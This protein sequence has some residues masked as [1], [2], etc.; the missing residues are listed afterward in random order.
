MTNLESTLTDN[1]IITSTGRLTIADRFSAIFFVA[2]IA[3][4]SV[5]NPRGVLELKAHGHTV[6]IHL[7]DKEMNDL[8]DIFSGINQSS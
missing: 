1:R 5:V 6:A 3:L 2:K 4:C 8:A 7:D